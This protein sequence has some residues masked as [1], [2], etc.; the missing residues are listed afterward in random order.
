MAKLNGTQASLL[1]FLH[2]GPR[3]GWE[4]LQEISSGL[5]RFWNVTQSHAYRELKALEEK[6]LIVAGEPGPRDR[7]PFRL[8]PKSR[9]AFA[10]WIQEEPGPEQ[11]RFP[12]LVSLWFGEYLPA[13]RLLQFVDCQRRIRQE[14][15]IQYRNAQTSPRWAR[16][17]P[18]RRAVLQFGI[19]Y[20]EAILRWLAELPAGDGRATGRRGRERASKGVVRSAGASKAVQ[21]EP[22]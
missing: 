12:L 1:G 11:L 6:A 21:E 19:R 15:L 14:R 8:T 22:V 2:E 13:E 20:E 18:R 9:K 10:Q 16:E 5:G 4:L 7:R 3:T 17:H